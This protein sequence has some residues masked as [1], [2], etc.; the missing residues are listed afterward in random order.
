[1]S[2]VHHWLACIDS[3]ELPPTT[4][5]VLARLARHMDA[6]GRR[7]YPSMDQ[8]AWSTGLA[9]R[10]IVTHINLA[11]EHGYLE[12]RTARH[13]A[14]QRWRSNEYRP[15]VPSGVEPLRWCDSERYRELHGPGTRSLFDA[16]P[17]EAPEAPEPSAAAAL[18][19]VPNPPEPSAAAALQLSIP[20]YPDDDAREREKERETNGCRAGTNGDR[21][22]RP[23][24]DPLAEA[25][26]DALDR[27]QRDDGGDDGPRLRPRTAPEYAQRLADAHGYHPAPA[28]T[29]PELA[30]WE[31]DAVTLAELDAA[32]ARARET[33][34]RQGRH[35]P[36]P[37]RYLS[38]TIESQRQ[39]ANRRQRPRPRPARARS[40]G[41][42]ALRPLRAAA[43]TPY[44][45][46]V[47]PPPPV[48]D[49]HAPPTFLRYAG[50][51]E[52]YDSHRAA[53]DL[54]SGRSPLRALTERRPRAPAHA[55]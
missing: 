53:L 51:A 54:R 23:P 30:R 31:A 7:C 1:M 55:L 13:T 43:P 29:D 32:H 4:R 34:G 39:A 40:G 17:D 35:D 24:A 33:R 10:T 49:P 27:A 36:P 52:L 50:G 16:A 26:P 21:A 48:P 38:L 37:L 3:S 28:A 41:S 14:A 45:P 47:D 19:S 18:G 22:E 44:R 8:L 5:H 9:K 6:H 42:G 20:L 11:V 12:R 2:I 15:C 25:S 46:P